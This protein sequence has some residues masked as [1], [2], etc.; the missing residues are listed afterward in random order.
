MINKP[1]LVV[2]ASEI[3]DEIDVNINKYREMDAEIDRLKRLQAEVKA[4][5][6]DKANKKGE[7][8]NAKGHLVATNKLYAGRKSV[9]AKELEKDMPDVYNAY[10]VVGKEY[11]RFC[12]K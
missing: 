2:R 5:L 8:Y 11:T 9:N 6:V 3:I 7:I 12:V 10:L 4:M 1:R